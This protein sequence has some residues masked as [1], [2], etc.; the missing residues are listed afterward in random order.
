MIITDSNTKEKSLI[1]NTNYIGDLAYIFN[2]EPFIVPITYFYDEEENKIICYSGTGH[3]ID[4]LRKKR[5][6]SLCVSN[7]NSV[8]NWESVLVKGNYKEHSGSGAKAILHKFSLGV[9]KIIL[10]KEK[11]DLDFINQFTSKIRGND[12][13]VIFTIEIEDIISKRR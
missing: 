11:R 10:T 4:A 5:A 13:P 3:K 2:D 1:L 12:I 8:S 6:V 7:I 9:K